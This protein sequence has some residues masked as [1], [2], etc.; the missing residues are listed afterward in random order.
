MVNSLR[1]AFNRTSIH[2]GSPPWFDPQDLG[3]NV[4]SY[5]PGEMVLTITG[6]FNIAA[7]TATTGIFNTNTYQMGDDLSMVR[8]NHQISFGA[9]T[10]YWKMDF[11]TH[12]RSGGDWN[13]NGQ[14]TGL[15]L[16]DF[17][18][19]RVARLEHGGPADMPMHMWYVGT[20]AQDT[21]RASQRVTVNAGVRWEPFL[22]QAL[23]NGAVY[24]FDIERF[25]RQRE[26]HGLH[27]RAGRLPLSRR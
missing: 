12:A 3:S 24:N 15:G 17:L 27:Q 25:R 6:G 20:Y 19:G 8:G 21:W 26:E 2:R 9:N 22:G 23:E 11:L 5:N 13:I 10:A 16:A 14:A 4:Y 1:F 7:G 18:V